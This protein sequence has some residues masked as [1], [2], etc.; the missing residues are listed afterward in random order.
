MDW[1]C[2]RP[3]V[4][5][6]QIVVSGYSFGSHWAMELAAIDDRVKAIATAAATYGPKRSLFEQAS[7][8]SK[9]VG[10]YMANIHDEEE[11]DAFA[12]SLIIDEFAPKVKCPALFCAGEY[13][14]VGPIE[15]VV[16]VYKMVPAP[17][18][19]WVVENGFHNPIGIPNFGGTAFFGVLADWL[20]DA[21]AGKK[22][23]D[24]DRTIV[25]PVHGGAGPYSEPVRG[26]FL[27]ERIGRNDTDLTEA[28]RG[29]AGVKKA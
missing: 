6:T 5:A 22:P 17:K 24:L 1:L 10:M 27:P 20:R 9:Q 8:R 23:A 18:E 19:L 7:P 26:V 13:D 16:E 12:D 3:E 25:I 4:D 28:Q 21:L 15:D 2:A 14:D 11:F 29:P